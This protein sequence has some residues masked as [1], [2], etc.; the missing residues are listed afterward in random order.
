M[1]NIIKHAH[2]TNFKSI[3][4]LRLEDCQRINLFIGYPNV[5]KSNLIEALSLFS[6]PFLESG[7]TLTGLSGWKIKMNFFIMPQINIVR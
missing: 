2:I 5:G 4:D 7:E 3:R 6:V 1:N